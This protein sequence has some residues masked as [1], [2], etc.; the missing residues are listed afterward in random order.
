MNNIELQEKLQ[1]TKTESIIELKNVKLLPVIAVAENSYQTEEDSLEMMD[2][3]Y[4]SMPL[5]WHEYVN[6][7]FKKA[8]IDKS[9]AVE[10]QSPYVHIDNISYKNLELVL[11]RHYKDFFKT[12]D[13]IPEYTLVYK[14]IEGGYILT[15]ENKSCI[16]TG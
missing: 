3:D 10:P 15:S 14:S 1:H 4:S 8:N 7:C 6:T 16:L 9:L 2:N 5:F 12:G 11:K 13:V